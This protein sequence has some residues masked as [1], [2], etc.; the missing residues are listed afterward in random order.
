MKTTNREVVSVLWY[1]VIAKKKKYIQQHSSAE[2]VWS[3]KYYIIPICFLSL[4]CELLLKEK[5]EESGPL[6][7]I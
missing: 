5:D 1:L 6:I 2:M 3:T 4:L 7:S